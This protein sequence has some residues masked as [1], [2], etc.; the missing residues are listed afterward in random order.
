VSL[1]PYVHVD[2][3]LTD[4]TTDERI[5]LTDAESHH[6]RRVLR[7]PEGADVEVADGIG[8]HA[9]ARL[10]GDDLVLSGDVAHRPADH[11]ELWVA[12]AL[13]K[14]RKLEEVLRQVTE[15]GADGIVVVAAQR[16]IPR[17][18]ASK[19]ARARQRWAGIV[20][21]ASEQARRPRRP[22]ITGPVAAADLADEPGR[23]VV[24]APGWRALPE[25]LAEHATAQRV[26]LAIGPEGGW[27]DDEVARF[28]DAGAALAGLGPTVLRTEHAAAAALAVA[29]AG[30][31]RW[32]ST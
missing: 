7:L 19:V 17:L 6:L 22:S 20:R 9:A 30:L 11:P 10:D 3:A 25:V 28:L 26:T 15:L 2:T 32:S 16:S 31:G 8:N 23:L 27:S 13:P 24:A 5:A 12:Q 1:V 29:V 18:D 4:R 14:G 21:A